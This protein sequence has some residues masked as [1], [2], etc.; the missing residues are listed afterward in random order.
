MAAVPPQPPTSPRPPVVATP[1]SRATLPK[2]SRLLRRRDFVRVQGRGRKLSDGILLALALPRG[3]GGPARLGI[4]VSSKV[5]NAVH[6]A[7]IRRQVREAFRPRRSQFPDR[8]GRGGDRPG[9]GAHRS[10][11]RRSS[12]PSTPSSGVW[13]RCS[14]E[15]ARRPAALP[16]AP[17]A[18]AHPRLPPGPQPPPSAGLSLSPFL[19]R[20]RAGGARGARPVEGAVADRLAARPLSA[21]RTRWAGSGTR[22]AREA[23]KGARRRRPPQVATASQ[24]PAVDT[25]RPSR[26]R[27][28][29][30]ESPFVI[31]AAG[32]SRR[33]LPEV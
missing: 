19:Q 11:R 25:P 27:A 18:G 20:L 31:G 26:P 10:P 21:F 33:R 8:R 29:R 32:P 23:L 17:A 9:C 24:V 16:R 30:W 15:L 5:G 2:S 6:R 7:R 4:T 3:D 14:R 1:S 13:R 22:T 28:R 12:A